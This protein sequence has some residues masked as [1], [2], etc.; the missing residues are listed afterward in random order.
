MAE[1][2]KGFLLSRQ[3][4]DRRNRPEVQ[5]W[6]VTDDQPVCLYV[7]DQSPV[8]FIE[9]AALFQA[10]KYLNS[11]QISFTS[12]S[13]AL[14]AFNHKPV[15]AIYFKTIDSSVRAQKILSSEALPIYE[16]D[17]RLHDRYLMERF[18]Y[19][20]LAFI[21]E[22]IQKQGYMEYRNARVRPDVFKPEFKVMSLDVECSAKGELY[23]V[24][25]HGDELNTVIMV[26]EQEQV[27]SE[28]INI[29]WVDDEQ[30]LLESLIQQVADYDPDIFIGW[31]V[32][33]FDF[34]LL[35]KRASRHKMP[36]SLGR[37]SQSCSWRERAN[38]PGQGFV[39]T[40]GRVV[41]DGIDALKS[42]TWHFD[43]FSLESVA[44]ALLGKGKAVDDVDNRMDAIT[45]DFLHD[46]QKLA[47]YNLQDCR[48]VSEIFEKT[49]LLD[50]LRL[51]SEMTG[52]ELDRMGGSVKAFTN[53]YLPKLHRAGYVSPNLPEGGG[54][55]SPGGY[56]MDSIPGL[57]NN[58]LVLD[59]KSLYPSI[60]R[61]F[62]VD[63]LGLIEG[64]KAPEAAIPGFK[65]AFFSRDNHFLPEIIT[66]LW[67][68]RDQAKAEKDS[69][70]S[71]AI[72]ILMNSFYGV[73]GSGGCRFYDTRLASSITMRGH[74][75]MQQTALWVEAF[76]HQV[77]YGDTDS[78]FVL[79]D[80][81]ISHDDADH[82]GLQL[83]ATITQRWQQRLQENFGLTSYLEMEYETHYRRF[84]MPTIRGS[85]T[86]SKK[87]YAGLKVTAEGEAL[88]CKGLET[89]RSDWTPLARDFQAALLNQ[90]FAGND[91]TAY[92]KETVNAVK[93]GI[94][95][96]QLVYRKR[97]RR[98]LSDYVKNVPPQVRAARLADE[99]NRQ[100]GK[101]LQYQNKGA[102]YYVMTI[103]GPE[104]IEYLNSAIDY[105]HYITK[106]LKPI[107]D[108]ILPFI[109][110][111]FDKM[112]SSQSSLF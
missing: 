31:N 89:V 46:K 40:P 50:Y 10:E 66:G 85:E 84:L 9:T 104:P 43:S 16:A 78:I 69:A 58:V 70:R 86:G 1:V 112:I 19:G 77:I 30:T 32:I 110:L 21:G 29:V 102:V 42:A 98:R 41:I 64:L 36:L 71:Q 7:E 8:F 91:P 27:I 35:V 52:L 103:N 99:Q 37:G 23:S 87:R 51:R 94:N 76:G 63:P 90:V 12:R 13:V 17:I 65:G 93:Q 75:I 54:L 101:P 39:T 68:Q 61:T 62:K 82:I 22:P 105:E 106:Q 108:G 92:V 88:I 4:G 95:S 38:E 96:E 81:N 28:G 47:R 6:L 33:N 24:G 18:T 60:I 79:L 14:A 97:L 11:A 49:R 34:R 100:A 57:Y 56:V 73:L 3:S 44:R 53:L 74:E 109:N 20:S 45:H 72:K 80:E 83:A 111:D 5:M 2:Q 107:A 15:T 59:F 25:L 26:G 48:L 55:A 67:Q